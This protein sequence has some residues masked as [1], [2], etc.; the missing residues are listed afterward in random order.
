MLSWIQ[1][2]GFRA[3]EELRLDDFRQFNLF[4]GPNGS[5]KTTVL[6]AILLWCAQGN[7]R[8]LVNFQGHRGVTTIRN[9]DPITR[10]LFYGYRDFGTA[11]IKAEAHA[12][13][14]KTL[15][16]TRDRESV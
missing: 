15:T 3:I 10:G 6:E 9:L 13:T 8:P 11:A 4:I 1:I 7:P 12:S 2:Q 16:I 14:P 5:C